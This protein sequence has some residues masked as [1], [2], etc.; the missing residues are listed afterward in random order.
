MNKPA[1]CPYFYRKRYLSAI[2]CDRFVKNRQNKQVSEHHTKELSRRS[3][4]KMKIKRLIS[5]VA[6]AVLLL[7]YTAS[8]FAAGETASVEAPSQVLPGSEFTVRVIFTAN[9]D[10]GSVRATLEYDSDIIEFKSGDF[11]NGGGGLCTVNGWAEN[12]SPTQTFTLTFKAVGRGNADILITQSSVYNDSG[13]LLGGPVGLAQV[14]VTDSA[15]TTTTV[16][17]PAVSGDISDTSSESS[18][19]TTTTT[20][21]Q[22]TAT[23]TTTTTANGGNAENSGGGNQGGNNS[24]SD[25]ETTASQTQ[26]KPDKPAAN[27]SSKP[28]KKGISEK[29][30]KM[31]V[32]AV[33]L[34]V[35]VILICCL[36]GGDSGSGSSRSQGSGRKRSSSRSSSARKKSSGSHSGSRS[37]SRTNSN[38]RKRR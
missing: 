5:A 30:K 23:T 17:T 28:E 6:A 7:I 20:S 29:S 21:S 33:F 12:I 10:I 31:V 38:A 19:Q 26:S 15:T 36:M 27:D 35:G 3:K 22:S 16:T 24:G 14:S 4:T 11:A 32:G 2:F 18:S 37:G 25:G 13:D 8:A 1:F 34:V 9:E